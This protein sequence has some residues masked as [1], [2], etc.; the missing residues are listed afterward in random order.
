MIISGGENVYP[1]E[2]D[3][4][5][6]QHPD[7]K[8]VA[9]VGCPDPKWG[10]RVSAAVALRAGAALSAEDLI[11]WS[12][13][14]LAG[15]KRPHEILFLSPERMPRNATGKILHRVLRDMMAACVF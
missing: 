7:V 13:D 3:A 15:D 2:V 9:V 8:D 14:R 1:T 10:E 11:V 5:I 12:K 6:A 4:V